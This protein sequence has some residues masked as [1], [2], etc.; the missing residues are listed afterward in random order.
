MA[1]D[2]RAERVRDL[3]AAV[4]ARRKAH[5]LTQAELGRFA[6]CGPDFV[7]D[8]ETGKPTIR[9][10]KLLDVLA[11]LGLELRLADG[12]R[13][14]AVEDAVRPPQQANGS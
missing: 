12:K 7:Y 10:D 11:V 13:A 9:L 14:L 1:P 4:R 3:A 5:R 8:L 6:G 2:T